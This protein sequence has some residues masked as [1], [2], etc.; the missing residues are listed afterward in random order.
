MRIPVG[1]AELG[2]DQLLQL[3]GDVVLEHLGLLVDAVPGHPEHLGQKELEQAVV[4][5]H[6]QGDLL[7]APGE[8]NAVVGGVLDQSLRRRAA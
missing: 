4:A 6:L 7:P 1:V 3:L 8:A 5:D 2:G